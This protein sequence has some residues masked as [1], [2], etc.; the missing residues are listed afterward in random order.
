MHEPS[1]WKLNFSSTFVKKILSTHFLRCKSPAK[2]KFIA[3]RYVFHLRQQ[4]IYS[5]KQHVSHSEISEDRN[6]PDVG[7]VHSLMESGKKNFFFSFFH[8]KGKSERGKYECKRENDIKS[9]FLI[10][11]TL[12]QRN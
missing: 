3:S 11:L 2:S 6:K 7:D 9:D 12:I 8:A 4:V 10:D 1:V 5:R